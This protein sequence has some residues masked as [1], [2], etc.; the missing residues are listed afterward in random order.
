MRKW[1]RHRFNRLRAL[2][3]AMP[4]LAAVYD[5]HSLVGRGSGNGSSIDKLIISGERL[6]TVLPLAL[7]MAALVYGLIS[8]VRALASRLMGASIAAQV[9]RHQIER[10][11]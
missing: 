7:T 4:L 1:W 11:S 6:V 5:A 10:R 2:F 3:T 9:A 8:L